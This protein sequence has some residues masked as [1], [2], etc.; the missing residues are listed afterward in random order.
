MVEVDSIQALPRERIGT[1]GARSLRREGKVPAIVYGGG[2]APVAIVLDERRLRRQLARPRFL[3]TL[4]HLDLDGGTLQVLPREV[5]R[6]PVTDAPL[7][8]DFV[9]AGAGSM[10]TVEVPVLFLNE[11]TS[12]GIKRG[13]V[14]NI[15]RREVELLCPVDR[16]PESLVLDLAEVDI[17]DSLHISHVTLPE[18][19]RPTITDRDF[20]I[21]AIVPPSGGV[22]DEE[23]GEGTAEADTGEA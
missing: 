9:R 23:E 13:G 12:R 11:E 10:V 21:A 4:L 7:H 8:V 22:Q 3:S 19:V 6:H 2:E 5:Q 17:G 15:V 20:T 18:G 14:L 16:I 1:G